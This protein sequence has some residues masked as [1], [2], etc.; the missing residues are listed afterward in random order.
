[1]KLLEKIKT[2]Y[3]NFKGLSTISIGTAITTIIGALFWLGMA[4]LLGTELYGQLSYLLAIAILASRIS[5]IGSAT[6]LM[7][8]GSKETKIKSPIFLSTI[9]SS[10]IISIV[11]F[12]AFLNDIG[13]SV[14]IIGFVIFTLVTSDLLGRKSYKEYAK[15]IIT[16]KILLVILAFSLFQIMG[17]EGVILGI[18]ISF[19]PYIGKIIKE[20]KNG[21]IDFSVLK[22]KREFMLNNYFMDLIAAFNGNIDKLII[23]P[24]LGFVL[25]GNYQL[26]IQFFSILTLL[27][28]VIFQYTLPHDASGNANINL[29]KS[30]III[31]VIFAI[32]G[33]VVFP[34]ISPI[35]FPEFIEV[36][37]LIQ[38][39]SLSLIPATITTTYNS[40]ILGAGKSRIV[41]IGSLI[42]L[43]VFVTS[44][45]ILG[46]MFGIN[47]VAAAMVLGTSMQAIFLIA[48]SKYQ[49]L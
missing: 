25:L 20:L 7:V 35:L 27:P 42:F 24:L 36:I 22:L 13:V 17:I 44:I 46:N 10:I 23:A 2:I 3:Q 30:I 9:V 31:S 4:P 16:Q 18:G 19:L 34:I 29:K 28:I 41:L 14:Y 5:L 38:I 39:I 33:I 11:V 45:I 43:G 26:A 6:T 49:K 8:Y 15:Y 37:Q 21:K 12:V 40:K 1:M 48:V 32:I 47:G